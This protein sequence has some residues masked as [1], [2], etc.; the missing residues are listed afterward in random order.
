MDNTNYTMKSIPL[1]DRPQE[2]LLKY[3]ANALSNSELIAVILRT[4]TK[5]ENVVMLAQRILKEDGKGLRN[6][7]E[8]T[9]EKFKSYKG[10]SDVK[11]SKLM[12]LAEISK[13]MSSLKIEK[14]KIS[15]P[16]D[17]AVIMMEEMRYYQKSTLK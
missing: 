12:A 10:I 16:D 6:I 1:D 8:G 7:A 4:G 3:G 13:R 5:E 14:I 11:A 15:S 17:A 9:I 2:K